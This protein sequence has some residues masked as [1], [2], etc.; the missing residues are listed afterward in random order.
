MTDFIRKTGSIWR[1]S[2]YVL[3]VGVNWLKMT[4]EECR[5][6]ARRYCRQIEAPLTEG[7]ALLSRRAPR[8]SPPTR[9]ICFYS[10]IEDE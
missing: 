9:I 4:Q 8:K 5:R 3:I 1:L 6:R 7:A 10:G 2:S